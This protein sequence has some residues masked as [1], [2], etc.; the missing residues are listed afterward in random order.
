MF[1]G[2]TLIQLLQL[3]YMNSSLLIISLQGRRV[4]NSHILSNLLVDLK[5]MLLS[6]LQLCL[7][8]L[9]RV[10]LVHK[11][12]NLKLIFLILLNHISK[13]LTSVGH[14]N[15]MSD[16]L[17]SEFLQLLISFLDLLIKSLVFNLE[18]LEINQ[19]ETIS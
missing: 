1:V 3:L 6:V 14:L 10:E 5:L 4:V 9:K 17:A 18:L 12:L 16:D 7:L 2:E 19:M 15:D 11:L 8:V 13:S